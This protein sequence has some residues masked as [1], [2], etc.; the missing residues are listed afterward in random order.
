MLVV[1]FIGTKIM[2]VAHTMF[3]FVEL[4]LA[5]VARKLHGFMFALMDG[6]TKKFQVIKAVVVFCTVDMV[7]FV[8]LGMHFTCFEPPNNM[9]SKGISFRITPWIIRSIDTKSSSIVRVSFIPMFGRPRFNINAL[10][11]SVWISHNPQY[12]RGS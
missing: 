3:S 1:A 10:E 4:V 7:Q 8:S 11:S 2:V 6:I 9:I 12:I 5:K